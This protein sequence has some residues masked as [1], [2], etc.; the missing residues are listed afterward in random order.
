MATFVTN[1]PACKKAIQ[2][3]TGPFAKKKVKCSC[4]YVIDVNTERM[5]TKICPHCGNKMLGYCECHKC[6]CLDPDHLEN[7][8]CPFCGSVSSYGGTISS[9]D[10]G[11][12]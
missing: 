2:V 12:G 7:V 1:C 4:G 10:G 5:E 9:I 3:S 6:L 11:R 8:K